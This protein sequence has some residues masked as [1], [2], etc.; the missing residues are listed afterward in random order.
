M[1][2]L[3]FKDLSR[4]L[5]RLG[6]AAGGKALRNAANRSML[7]ALKAARTAAPVASPPYVYDGHA[8][9]DPYPRKTYKGRLVSP[10]FTARSVTRRSFLSRDRKTAVVILGVKPEAFYSL[11]FGE[12]G[13]SRQA[14]APWLEPSFRSSIAAINNQFRRLLKAN[15][16]KAARR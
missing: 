1:P 15:L 9:V 4:Q 7:P 8:P 5:S 12:F 11:I 13:T 6:A 14:A 10:G 3:G 2:I 16:D